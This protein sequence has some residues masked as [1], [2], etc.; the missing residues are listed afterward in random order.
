[1][2]PGL[3]G[4]LLGTK[5]Y[6][7]KIYGLIWENTLL[8]EDWD[9]VSDQ[10]R[11]SGCWMGLRSLRTPNDCKMNCFAQLHKL[12]AAK[13][14]NCKMSRLLDFSS[15][16]MHQNHIFHSFARDPTVWA[17]ST[18]VPLSWW[19]GG[20]AA[21]HQEHYPVATVSP[22]GRA[23]DFSFSG[24]VSQSRVARPPNHWLKWRLCRGL[25]N[26]YSILLPR[27]AMHPGTSHGPLSVSVTSRS[28]TKTAKRRITQTTPHNSPGNLVFWCPR[29]LRNSIR[30]TPYGGAKCRWGGS[31]SATFDK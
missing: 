23:S 19:E 15:L 9:F 13:P 30:V 8:E 16:E 1:M 6:I 2:L 11:H 12:K 31:K 5:W 29:F 7:A 17:Y 10:G 26:Y 3:L 27:D 28:S 14:C 24:L 21:P 20:L 18:A 22:S 4:I 25:L